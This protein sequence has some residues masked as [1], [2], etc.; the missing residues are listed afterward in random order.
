MPKCWHEKECNGYC[1]L[2]ITNEEYIQSFN[3]ECIL[4]VMIDRISY[5]EQEVIRLESSI[6]K[7]IQEAK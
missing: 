7:S 4:E 3:K 1:P 5:L 6:H 2:F